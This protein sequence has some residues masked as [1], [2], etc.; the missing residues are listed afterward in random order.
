MIRATFGVES[1]NTYQMLHD[2]SEIILDKNIDTS[3]IFLPI[4]PW[5]AKRSVGRLDFGSWLS[6]GQ[7]N[8]TDPAI[9]VL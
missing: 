1:F 6:S 4:A 2:F 9:F 3:Q 5:I 8:F 7:R